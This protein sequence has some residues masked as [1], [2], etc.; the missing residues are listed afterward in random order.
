MNAKLNMNSKNSFI[1]V[2]I[3]KNH[4]DA[5]RTSDLVTKTFPNSPEGFKQF[6]EWS[7][8]CSP[9]LV[10]CEDTG[11][12]EKKL[13]IAL[14]DADIPFRSVNPL[15]V[16][17]YAK[18]LGILAKTDKIDAKVL[19][20]FAAERNLSPQQIPSETQMILQELWVWRRQ[21]I[22]EKVAHKNHLEH[23]TYKTIIKG[24]KSLMEKIDQQIEKVEAE[25]NAFIS[26]D[27]HWSNINDILQSIP[28]IGP[29]TARTL[30]AEL[31]DL[32]QGDGSKFCS[33]AGLVPYN[34][35]SGPFRGQRHIH[36]GRSSIRNVLYMAAL[37]AVKSV[38]AN[39]VF[40]ELYERITSKR[41]AKVGLI[42]VAHK[43]L[44]IAHA[45]VK[46]NIQWENKLSPKTS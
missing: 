21:L 1:G 19:A 46:N 18:S 13:L 28:G 14:A 2:D 38:K 31:P 10:L 33:L 40:K 3:S 27:P 44:L 22:Q 32:G 8:E 15:R 6:I 11:G 42:A 41:P 5:H 29:E 9:A 16:R 20:Q 37:T 34:Y 43:M 4:L 35:D 45:L 7:R 12:Y 23:A 17:D 25:M 39:N 30:I 26:S 24:T 36:G